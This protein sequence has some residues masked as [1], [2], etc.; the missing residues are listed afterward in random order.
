[1]VIKD[2]QALKEE[3][4]DFLVKYSR[5][6]Y[7][8]VVLILDASAMV[9]G[10]LFLDGL[11]KYGK[12]WRFKESIRIDAFLLSRNIDARK[13]DAALRILNQLLQTE[14]SPNGF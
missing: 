11:A 6:P 2:V 1:V 10:M 9:I 4:K 3:A 5:K 12:V 8:H 7:A 13:S 14:R